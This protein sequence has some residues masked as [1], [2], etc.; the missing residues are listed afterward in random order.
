M[1]AGVPQGFLLGPLIFN[2]FINDLNDF[3]STVSL[4]LNA[5]DTTEYL[6]D[7]SPTVLHYTINKELNAIKE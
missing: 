4:R 6:P 3:I 2:I 5:D 1:T 7:H